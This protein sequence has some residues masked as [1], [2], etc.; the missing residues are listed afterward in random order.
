M[1]LEEQNPIT[2][3][4]GICLGLTRYRYQCKRKRSVNP[5]RFL[6]RVKNDLNLPE[7]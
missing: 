1:Q 5:G 3:D 4:N 6:P 2:A 7:L